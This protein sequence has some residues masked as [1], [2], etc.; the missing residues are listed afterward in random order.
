M[1][2]F[3]NATVPPTYACLAA[4]GS[5]QCD[6]EGYASLRPLAR[7]RERWNVQVSGPGGEAEDACVVAYGSC[8]RRGVYAVFRQF[9]AHSAGGR[10]CCVVC[11]TSEEGQGWRRGMRDEGSARDD[12]GPRRSNPAAV[13][14]RTESRTCAHHQ[15]TTDGGRDRTGANSVAVALEAQVLSNQRHISEGMP[16]SRRKTAQWPRLANP[17]V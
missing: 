14:K 2:P 11:G 7:G 16:L 1:P 10:L 9:G 13:A 8:G 17:P 3:C 12:C 15:G 6:W 5:P 4:F